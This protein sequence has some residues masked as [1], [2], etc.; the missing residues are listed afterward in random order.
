MAEIVGLTTNSFCRFFKKVNQ[1]SFVQFVNEFRINKAI[2]MMNLNYSSIFETMYACGFN[3]PS[4][5]NRQ[6]K[7]LKECPHLI[8]VNKFGKPN[9]ILLKYE[10]FSLTN[11]YTYEQVCMYV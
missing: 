6:L 4:F 9:N 8:I 3:D 10:P 5:F 7:K 2:E 1:K 11:R